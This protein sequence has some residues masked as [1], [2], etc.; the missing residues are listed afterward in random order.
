MPAAVEEAAE[1]RADTTDEGSIAS[2][3]ATEAGRSLQS[4]AQ[5]SVTSGLMLDEKSYLGA[6]AELQEDDPDAKDK[7]KK[8]Q[9]HFEKSE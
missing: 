5:S 2:G 4:S 7:D 8:D 9:G 6:F 3:R 1:A